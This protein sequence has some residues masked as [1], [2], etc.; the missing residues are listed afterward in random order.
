MNTS[1]QDANR[2]SLNFVRDLA[3]ESRVAELYDDSLPYHN[4]AHIHDTLAAAAEIIDRCHEERIRVDTRI[5]YFALLFH[6]AGY[7]KDHRL[8]GFE[9]KED[10]SAALAEQHLAQLDVTQKDRA[11]IA[12]AIM[13]THRDATFVTAEQKLV[14]AADLAGLSAPYATFLENSIQLWKEQQLLNGPLSWEAWR[15]SVNETIGFYLSQEIRLTSYYN[16]DAGSS[17]FHLAVE[18]N[19]KRFC[20]EPPP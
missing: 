1:P 20:K 4:F 13:A 2:I 15:T 11:K 17:T 6:D 16:D 8:L 12:A 18:A 9:S 19:L 10:Y 3:L 14:R 7:H 5:V